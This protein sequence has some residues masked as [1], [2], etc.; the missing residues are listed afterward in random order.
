MAGNT[1]EDLADKVRRL[2]ALTSDPHPGLA[3][4]CSLLVKAEAELTEVLAARADESREAAKRAE[5]CAFIRCGHPRNE[6]IKHAE[7]GYICN[8][9]MSDTVHHKFVEPEPDPIPAHESEGAAPEY[10]PPNISS[11]VVLLSLM[12]GSLEVDTPE[13]MRRNLDSAA[14]LVIPNWPAKFTWWLKS[15]AEWDEWIREMGFL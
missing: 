3:T 12:R 9:C 15:P 14:F 11:K 2:H 5:A 10:K 13:D 7:A 6:H 8:R 1:F 4:W